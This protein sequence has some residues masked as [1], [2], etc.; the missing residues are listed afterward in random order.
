MGLVRDGRVVGRRTA[1]VCVRGSARSLDLT[2]APGW[3]RVLFDP[4]L[5]LVVL[6]RGVQLDLGATAKALAADRAARRIHLALGAV[7]SSTSVV[8]SGSPVRNPPGA[9]RSRSAMTTP[10]PSPGRTAPVALT[11]GGL[12]TSGTARRRW[13]H[14]GRHRAPHRRPAHR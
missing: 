3:H 14:G 2:P 5:R 1:P 8:T 4:A 7:S 13:R 12:A 9:G 11:T 6:P 10:K